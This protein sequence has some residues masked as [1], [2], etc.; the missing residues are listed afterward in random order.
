MRAWLFALLLCLALPAGAQH[1]AV[2]R[3][4]LAEFATSVDG[5]WKT[6]Q[7]PDSWVQRGLATGSRGIYRFEFE[8]QA[9]PQLPWALWAERLSNAHELWINGQHLSGDL[10]QD[11]LQHRGRMQTLWIGIPPVMLRPGINTLELRVDNGPRA[12][13]SVLNLGPA[14]PGRGAGG[15]GYRLRPTTRRA[16]SATPC[17]VSPMISSTWSHVADSP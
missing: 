10:G 4:T 12:G 14:E 9:R 7:L 17:A 11:A 1:E 13:L 15:G 8:L 2:T 3:L 16:A 5:P 6:V